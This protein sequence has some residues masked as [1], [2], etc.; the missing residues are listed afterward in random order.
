VS[1]AYFSPCIPAALLGALAV[2]LAQ[3]LKA[4]QMSNALAQSSSGPL[5]CEIQKA[6]QGDRI[7]LVGLVASSRPLTGSAQFSF[8]KSGASGSS[9]IAQSQRFTIRA[10]EPMIVGRAT[11]NLDSGGRIAIDLHVEAGGLECRARASLER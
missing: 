11:T 9:N 5:R 4:E 6:D 1:V 10:D 8:A 2:V 3:P 7:E